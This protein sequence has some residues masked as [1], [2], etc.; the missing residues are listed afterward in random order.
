MHQEI[1]R[2]KTLLDDEKK[3]KLA[4]S[5]ENSKEIIELKNKVKDLGNF[6]S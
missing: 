6:K 5:V 4:I 1:S 2:L 3:S